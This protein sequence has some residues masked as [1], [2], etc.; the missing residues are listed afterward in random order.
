[1][2]VSIFWSLVVLRSRARPT[3]ENGVELP[4][5]TQP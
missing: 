4:W 2:K 1:M 3:I 5:A